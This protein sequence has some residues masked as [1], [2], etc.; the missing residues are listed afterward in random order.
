MAALKCCV[1]RMA[2][3]VAQVKFSQLPCRQKKAPLGVAGGAASVTLR[4]EAG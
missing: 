4:I 1:A 3:V 2:G